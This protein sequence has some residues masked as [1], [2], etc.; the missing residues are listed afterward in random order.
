MRANLCGIYFSI[1]GKL[2]TL[3]LSG[4]IALEAA[5]LPDSRRVSSLGKL[6]TLLLSGG[7][8]LEA[9]QLPDSRR[10]SSLL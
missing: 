4:G 9:A 1:Y 2:E 8:A 3:L 10:V 5:Q 6:E 7:I